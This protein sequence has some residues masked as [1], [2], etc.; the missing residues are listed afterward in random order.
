MSLLNKSQAEAVYS[1]LCALNNVGN[2]S[3]EI[4]I[5][6]GIN[7]KFNVYGGVYVS[8]AQDSGFVKRAFY[9]QSDFAEAFGLNE[10]VA[11]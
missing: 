4:N 7:V 5:P 10:G 11:A 2:C 1:A 8:R 6:D 9:S 3:G